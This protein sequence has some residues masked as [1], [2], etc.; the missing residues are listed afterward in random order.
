MKQVSLKLKIAAAVFFAVAALIIILNVTAPP[1]FSDVVFSTAVYDRNGKLLRLTLA[2]DGIYRV[3]APIDNISAK[4]VDATLLYED[5]WFY[6]HFGVNPVSLVRGFVSLIKND[7]RPLGASTITMQLARIKFNIDSKS[8]PGKIYQI[9]CALY[10]EICYSKQEILEA[11]L[12][13]APYGHNIEGIAAASLI[14][15]DTPSSK[16]SSFES[17]TLAVIPQNP[18]GRTPTKKTGME[19]I[20]EARKRLLASWMEKYPGDKNYQSLYN[21]NIPVNRPEDLPFHAPHFIN[22]ILKVGNLG[23]IHTALDLN[24]QNILEKNI[25]SYIFHNASYGVKNAAAL[26][27]D[28]ETSD[29]L[30]YV[31]SGDFFNSS[32]SGQVDGVTAYR[33][34]G[35][36][37]KPFIF[38]LAIDQGL[39]HPKSMMK[40]APKRYGSYSPENSDGGFMGPIFASAALVNS[41][42]IPAID[43]LNRL[44]N[45][46][47]YNLLK[48]AGVKRLKNE[49]FYG[50]ALA[51]GGFEMS[52]LDIGIFYNGL[53][54]YGVVSP[55]NFIK[56][57]KMSYGKGFKLFSEEA[58]YLVTYMLSGNPKL[59]GY[60]NVGRVAWKT[61][62]SFAF[63]DAWTAGIFGK[64]VLI[65]WVGN[66]DGE[67]NPTFTGRGAAAKIFF[68]I[69][70]SIKS[71][72]NEAFTERIPPK[73]LKI[74]DV[75]ICSPTGDLPGKFCPQTEKGKFIPGVSPIKVSDI[76]REV[77]IDKATGL[78][79]CVYDKE[80]SYLKVYEFWPSDLYELFLKS[81]IRKN[82][83]PPFVPGC[84]IEDKGVFSKAPTISSPSSLTTYYIS[85]YEVGS[86]EIGFTAT[87]DAGAKKIFWFVDGKLEGE[88]ASGTP[89]FW[90]AIPGRH[91]VTVADDAGKSDTL[92]FDIR[93]H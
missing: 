23:N 69:I 81:G 34:P 90:K 72:R 77:A 12:N 33:S 22:N 44:D 56:D 48:E 50:S 53:A 59:D 85:K 79:A 13:M 39:I 57:G 32:I 78:R 60:D 83:P 47:F 5:K 21:M 31:G 54:N 27:I 63:K 73:I 62:T 14:Y 89:L 58:A 92:F 49:K 19:K 52:M 10:L 68:S 9:L 51:L 8:V 64:Y 80:T 4:F 26:L 61:G 86:K 17:V 24:Y 74:K 6:R 71:Y 46:S 91:K 3:H 7:P 2:A 45:G 36:A 40:D 66:F 43:L 18:S 1:I 15:F 42:N 84:D 38:G 35:S 25:N 65:T 70:N 41:R 82:L 28:V 30:A 55:V 29:I 75:D 11:Y 16:L 76:F 88:V 93:L 37:M 67:G 20:I 87:V